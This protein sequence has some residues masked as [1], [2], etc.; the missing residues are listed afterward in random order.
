M[1]IISTG[2]LLL[3]YGEAEFHWMGFSLVMTAACLAGLRW[4]L[5]QVL[6]QG[7][8][9]PAGSAPSHGGPLD[10]LETL[11]PGTGKV[12]TNLTELTGIGCCWDRVNPPGSGVRLCEAFKFG[13]CTMEVERSWRFH[14]CIVP[15]IIIITPFEAQLL[16]SLLCLLVLLKDLRSKGQYSLPFKPMW[17]QFEASHEL[18][19]PILEVF[20]QGVYPS[21]SALHHYASGPFVTSEMAS[22]VIL[23]LLMVPTCCKQHSPFCCIFCPWYRTSGFLFACMRSLDRSM[24]WYQLHL[25]IGPSFWQKDVTTAMMCSLCSMYSLFSPSKYPMWETHSYL[26]YLSIMVLL[27]MR[28]DS[29]SHTS[30]HQS[31][32]LIIWWLITIT[33]FL[34]S[35]CFNWNFLYYLGSVL[36]LGV[37]SFDVGP[38]PVNSLNELREFY[39]LVWSGWDHNLPNA[40]IDHPLNHW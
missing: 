38:V 28:R 20:P 40:S 22:T 16:H 14:H 34:I 33:I 24:C 4:S 1:A 30:H 39:H 21:F 11:M 12:K 7:D 5:T 18:F 8:R 37:P 32:L 2:I 35:C 3:V 10:V 15:V 23:S 17:Q 27:W 31:V 25:V 26:S 36:F 9:R 29:L 13:V 19:H 6:L